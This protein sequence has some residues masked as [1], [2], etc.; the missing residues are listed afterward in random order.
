MSDDEFIRQ[1]INIVLKRVNGTIGDETRGTPLF[2]SASIPG[3]GIGRYLQRLDKYFDC[4]EACHVLALIYLQHFSDLS[5]D[6]ALTLRNVHRLYLIS[7]V[8][9]AKFWDD[10]FFDNTYYARC[11]GIRLPEL[12][13]LELT[14]LGVLNFK[15]WISAEEFQGALKSFDLTVEPNSKLS[16]NCRFSPSRSQSTCDG[17]ASASEES[18]AN[19]DEK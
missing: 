8:S 11:G 7:L 13:R 10:V 17:S 4:S 6:F 19:I 5:D 18:D 3:I 9:A 12:N 14:F 15:L 16:V 2:D 1:I